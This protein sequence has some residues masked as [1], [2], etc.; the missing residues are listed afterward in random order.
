M[1]SQ[2]KQQSNPLR[3]QI[4]NL[5]ANHNELRRPPK[6][7]GQ[8]EKVFACFRTYGIG[9]AT[10]QGTVTLEDGKEYYT[11]ITQF[12]GTELIEDV[13]EDGEQGKRYAPLLG[14][15]SNVEHL[16]TELYKY[17]G[18]VFPLPPETNFTILVSEEDFN[19]LRDIS[20]GNS[21]GVKSNEGIGESQNA[22]VFR[23]EVSRVHPIAILCTTARDEHGKAVGFNY[24]PSAILTEPVKLEE[25]KNVMGYSLYGNE[26]PYS[27]LTT[28]EVTHELVAHLLNCITNNREYGFGQSLANASRHYQ[29]R[30]GNKGLD[31]FR[32]GDKNNKSLDRSSE[33]VTPTNFMGD[34][35]DEVQTSS[36]IRIN[37]PTF[38][39]SRMTYR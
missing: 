39:T 24:T 5:P 14:C 19:M 21:I 4:F 6:L 38:P 17:A 37:T 2:Q 35:E 26:F 23:I 30:A 25:G 10:S 22:W 34:D 27:R 8:D 29:Q 36:P 18:E 33:P 15:L 7:Q 32:N 12:Q 11:I 9:E 13:E 31:R 16:P 1:T 3:N 20:K 28:Q